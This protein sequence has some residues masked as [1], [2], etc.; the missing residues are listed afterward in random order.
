MNKN[1][2]QSYGD[3]ELRIQYFFKV[4]YCQQSHLKKTNWETGLHLKAV[5]KHGL[6]QETESQDMPNDIVRFAQTW[7]SVT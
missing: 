2:N 6:E 4:I 7:F 3:E 5:K 1:E